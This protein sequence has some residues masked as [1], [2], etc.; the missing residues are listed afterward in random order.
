M[1]QN[2]LREYGTGWFAPVCKECYVVVSGGDVIGC[3]RKFREAS[4]A[5]ET[6]SNSLE[7]TNVKL[8][9]VKEVI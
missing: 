2:F 9:Q 1:C 4:M 7:T 8:Y 5:Y 6:Y 3:F